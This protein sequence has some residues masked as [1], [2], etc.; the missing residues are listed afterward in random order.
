[1]EIIK[2]KKLCKEDVTFLAHLAQEY[3]QAHETL[4]FKE[5]YKEIFIK[6]FEELL[7][8][9]E[10]VAIVAKVNGEIAGMIVGI[11]DDN[12]KLMLSEKIGY[13]PFL[14]VLKKFRRNGIGQKLIDELIGWFKEKN[15]D[16]VELYTSIDNYDAREFWEKNG[17]SIYLERR[18]IEI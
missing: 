2:L 6:Y 9:N 1:V 10:K 7:K 5:D 3:R 15:I 4:K 16:L 12:S 17:F 13:V 8:E 14:T 18:F 11:V